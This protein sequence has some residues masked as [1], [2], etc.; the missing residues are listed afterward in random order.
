M[1]DSI[2]PAKNAAEFRKAE[3]LARKMAASV[4]HSCHPEI[5]GSDC[6]E[7]QSGPVKIETVCD[8]GQAVRKSRKVQDLSQQQ[9]ADLAGVGRRF[10]SELEQGKE[11]LEFGRVLKVASACGIRITID[12]K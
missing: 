1:S 5:L 2:K 10:I 3:E 11:T 12:R 9:F 6:N 4:D 7:L 8:L